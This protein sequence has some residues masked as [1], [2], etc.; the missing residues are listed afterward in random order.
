M[1]LLHFAPETALGERLRRHLADGYL[2]ADLDDPNAMLEVDIS[3]MPFPEASFD[4]IYCSH[5]LEHVE[6]DRRGME[7]M[8]RV[9]RPNGWALIMV[10]ITAER[11]F[12]DPTITR[13]EDRLALFGQADHVRR[14]GPDVV[15]RLRSAGFEVQ[16]MEPRELA[17]P[18]DIERMGITPHAGELFICRPR[19]SRAT[20]SRRVRPMGTP[21]AG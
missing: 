2:S 17:S 7:E 6:Q 1:R 8:V 12:E 9:L 4:A 16:I 10:P 19:I 11:T 20:A 13:P 3:D 21:D 14:Y 5:V 18:A 15:D